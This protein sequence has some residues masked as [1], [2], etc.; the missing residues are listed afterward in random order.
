MA[1][2]EDWENEEENEAGPVF[3]SAGAP[4]GY[5]PASSTASAGQ[6]EQPPESRYVNFDRYFAAN[7]GS[8]TQS[9]N[10]LADGLERGAREANQSLE[11]Y[12]NDFSRR[13]NASADREVPV[14]SRQVG[15]GAEFYARPLTY[16]GP[17][18]FSD[19]SRVEDI[20]A[21][22]DRARDDIRTAQ[23]NEGVEAL[24]ERG[25]NLNPSWGAGRFDA[26]LVGHAGRKRF[27][28]LWDKFQGLPDRVDER[29]T[30]AGL[31][32]SG[33]QKRLAQRNATAQDKAAAL[34]R[35][36]RDRLAADARA[37]QEAERERDQERWRNPNQG[38]W[39]FNP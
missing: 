14:E 13:V 3:L 2:R 33:A 34:N 20:R 7:A 35:A 23:G 18:D 1:Y 8:A 26:A 37:R 9:A 29:A 16:D 5:Q 12:S 22:M 30:A 6:I 24:L 28:S 17:T 11:D 27:A 39:G 4:G 32:V 38:R 36:E 31:E 10:E 21:R 15:G 25:G 19:D